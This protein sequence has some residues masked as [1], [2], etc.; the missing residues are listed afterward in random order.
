MNARLQARV[1]ECAA[2]IIGGRKQ[3]CD[4][5]GI[6]ASQLSRWMTSEETSPLPAFLGAVDVILASKQGFGAIFTKHIATT[7]H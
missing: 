6:E 5:L 1:F 4:H 7:L 2:E 3:L